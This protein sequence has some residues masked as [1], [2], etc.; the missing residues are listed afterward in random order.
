MPP[1]YSVER[2]CA[3]EIDWV[4]LPRHVELTA[5]FVEKAEVGHLRHRKGLADV[6]SRRVRSIIN[7]TAGFTRLSRDRRQAKNLRISR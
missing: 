1:N 4:L 5:R 6:A 7:C 3:S 2:E